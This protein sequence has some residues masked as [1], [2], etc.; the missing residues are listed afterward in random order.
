[1][2]RCG[3]ERLSDRNAG[4]LARETSRAFAHAASIQI[5]EAGPL[6]TEQGGVNFEAIRS[7]IAA[8]LHEVPRLRQR[9]RWIPLEKH[10]IWVDDPD[11]NLGYH[12]RHT[13]LPRPGGFPLLEAMAARIMASWRSAWTVRV[14]SGSAGCSRV[15]RV[16]A[17][18]RS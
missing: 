4:Y 15:S 9:L 18:P 3:Y 8:R 1:M 13:S 14:R 2:A 17:S 12:L 7:G 6:G 11:F 16:D 10:P 5:F